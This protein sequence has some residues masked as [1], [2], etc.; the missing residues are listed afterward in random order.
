MGRKS[1]IQDYMKSAASRAPAMRA[2]GAL[3]A[4]RDAQFLSVG[5]L[6]PLPSF[7]PEPEFEPE[8]DFLTAHGHP[9]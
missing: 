1:R 4:R 7:E 9:T 3:K 5:L 2:S 8:L 6:D